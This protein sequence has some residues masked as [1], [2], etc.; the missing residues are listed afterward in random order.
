ML[1]QNLEAQKFIFDKIG[2]ENGLPD[3]NL[4]CVFRDRSG[5]LWIGSGTGLIRY[6]S[7]DFAIYKKNPADSVSI[8]N[9][10][11]Y[12]I[13]ESTNG[14]LWLA[15]E[16]GISIFDTDRKFFRTFHAPSG[17]E[18]LSGP[19][20]RIKSIGDRILFACGNHLFTSDNSGKIVHPIHLSDNTHWNPIT[21]ISHCGDGTIWISTWHALFLLDASYNLLRT[22]YPGKNQNQISGYRSVYSDPQITG[23][24]WSCATTGGIFYFDETGDAEFMGAENSELRDMASYNDSTLVAVGINGLIHFKINTGEFIFDDEN[25]KSTFALKENSFDQINRI[26]LDK[27]GILWVTTGSGLAQVNPLHQFF[28]Y[29]D[30]L[31]VDENIEEMCS[32]ENDEIFTIITKNGLRGIQHIQYTNRKVHFTPL[33]NLLQKDF[34]DIQLCDDGQG[35]LWLA[36]YCGVYTYNKK[37]QQIREKTDQTNQIKTSDACIHDMILS[38]NNL[39]FISN[40]QFFKYDLEIKKFIPLHKL[41]PVMNNF[42]RHLAEGYN[43][44][45]HFLI[46]PL[47]IVTYDFTNSTFSTYCI[48]KNS[49]TELKNVE[50]LSLACTK[51]DHIYV[52]TVN[53]G[54]IHFYPGHFLE[55]RKLD[56]FDQRDGLPSS[57]IH[58]LATDR[59][60]NIWTGGRDGLG[61]I[62]PDGRIQVFNAQEGIGFNLIQQLYDLRGINRIFALIP[63]IIIDP[64]FAFIPPGNFQIIIENF[65]LTNDNEQI[66]F[67]KNGLTLP[68]DQNAFNISFTALDFFNSHRLEYRYKLE[69]LNQEWIQAGSS[70]TLNYASVPPGDY[71]LVIEGI[72]SVYENR[73]GS[74]R[75]P[76]VIVPAYYQRIW[77]KLLCALILTAIVFFIAYNFRNQHYK[78]KLAQ[79][80]KDKAL[81]SMRIDISQDMH[82]EIGAGLTLISLQGQ[83]TLRNF[84]NA[85][86]K[87]KDNV[88]KIVSNAQ[89]LTQNLNEIIWSI[90]PRHDQ[91]ESFL[92]FLRNYCTNF[93][94][95][96]HFSFTMQIPSEQSNVQIS[97]E[98]RRNV[99]L[100]L[101][102]A[103]HNAVKYSDAK[104][105]LIR[106]E[107]KK[108]QFK[109]S[110]Q[111]DGIGFDIHSCKTGNGLSGMKNRSEKLTGKLLIESIPGKGTLVNLDCTFPEIV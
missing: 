3:E 30:E 61:K 76:I 81:N 27:E 103:L 85:P 90:N 37:T 43:K 101:K 86:R 62:Y 91:F 92:A 69:G 45:I 46:S 75:V 53:H 109:M 100:I 78:V 42:K 15:T 4:L 18:E 49:G 38:Q 104:A 65:V 56:V 1:F 34:Y 40:D 22:I 63:N 60:G 44:Q 107:T 19:I 79:L 97:P 105:I 8:C 52:G 17:F 58:T 102:E 111:D 20:K 23:K 54:M 110:I 72:D 59:A 80:E 71:V 108:N 24:Y 89:S 29:F 5:I 93:L 88:E 74:V 9:N 67:Q 16:G 35:F 84:E 31:G 55:S 10:T 36:G 47:E 50:F 57:F 106:I 25:N 94:E 99:F 41:S 12:D 33:P 98:W 11:V 70:R 51:D 13:T 73:K 14:E 2:Y 66:P 68:H 28:T 48:E 21:A 32:S 64:D 87:A 82:D 95:E 7:N 83:S 39:F 96:T 26:L 77:F 6:N